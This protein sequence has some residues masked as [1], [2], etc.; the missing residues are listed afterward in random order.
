[1]VPEEHPQDREKGVWWLQVKVW[2][3]AAISISLLSACFIVRSVDWSCCPTLWSSFQSSCYFVSTV[4]QSWAQHWKN[5]SMMGAHLAV[6]STEDE[7]DFIIQNLDEDFA[8]FM[9][10]SD[11]EGQRHWQWVDQTPYNKSATFWHSGEPNDPLERCVVVNFR[12]PSRKWGWNDVH[13]HEPEKSIC[14]MMKIYL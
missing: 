14:E 2:S 1:M 6:I 9:G 13:C 8:Y 11:P 7:Q 10:L 3:V 4:R 5:C 12:H